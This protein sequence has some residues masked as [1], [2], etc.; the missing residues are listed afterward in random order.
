MTNSIPCFVRDI[1]TR[2]VAVLYVEQNLE[3]AEW[4][5][6]ELRFRHLPVVDA[7]KVVGVAHSQF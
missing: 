7:G 2:K 5:M 4:G 1:M 3:L 6:K